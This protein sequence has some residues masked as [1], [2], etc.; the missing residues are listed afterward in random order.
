MNNNIV[1]ISLKSFVFWLIILISLATYISAIGIYFII[2]EKNL[3]DFTTK[4]QL[5]Y[6]NLIEKIETGEV[7]K[8][9][10][11][12]HIK[13]TESLLEA[14]Y[15]PPT[16]LESIDE[17]FKKT[18]LLIERRYNKSCLSCHQNKKIGESAGGFLIKF[19]LQESYL[20]S[21]KIN[22]NIFFLLSPIPLLG[23]YL[24][25]SFTTKKIDRFKNQLKKEIEHINKVEQLA[26]IE[27]I[28]KEIFILELDEIF[29]EL[30]K[31][32]KKTR[33]TAVDRD[34]LE[35]EIKILEKFLITSDV[36]KDWRKYV[37]SLIS[38]INQV[39]NIQ[40][41]FSLFRISENDFS[42]EFFWTSHPSEELKE[43]AEKMIEIRCREFYKPYCEFKSISVHHA[44][45]PSDKCEIFHPNMLH[46]E[47]KSLILEEPKIGG[48]IG[49]GVNT[50]HS[51]DKIK[52][53]VIEG[54][55]TTLL[56][57][58]GSV[59]AISRYNKEL[60]YYSTRDH[61]TNLFNQRVFWE[62]LTYQVARD[63]RHGRKFALLII[64]LDN[65]KFLN[66]NCGH[67][68][69]DRFLS[70]VS[71][72]IKKSVRLGDI[73]ARYSGDEFTVIMPETDSEEAYNVAIRLI[74]KI[75]KFKFH[76][77]DKTISVTAS[78]GYAI[79]PDHGSEA[80]ELFAFADTMLFKA[81]SEGKNK[82]LVP[83]D[84][85]I[86]F[87]N[88]MISEKSYQII[89][90]I[91]ENRIIPY[92]QPIMDLKT[93]SI[94]NYEVLCRIDMGDK[95][96]SAY[97]F[98][99]IAERTGNITKIDYLMMENAFKILT[100]HPGKTLFINLSPKSLIITEFIPNVLKITSK[101]G[102]KPDNI[103][104]ELT[105]R[106]TVKNISALEKFVANL[107]SEGYKFAI[108]DFGSGFSSYEYIK[109]FP[110]DFVK[111][112]GDFIK[113]ILTSSKD[114]A[115]VKSLLILTEEF[116]IK[117]IAEFIENQEI[118]DKIKELNINY[119]QGYFIG[120]PQKNMII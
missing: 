12:N 100:Q 88:R 113:N 68:V 96:V 16:K 17:S 5:R 95:I 74:D 60:E 45:I 91:E 93:G 67:D 37:A 20:A 85:D 73:V 8:F 58:I 9:Q 26:K 14:T 66:D 76:Q 80:K 65:F 52:S 47:T 86:A 69:G 1:K 75:E 97:E 118:F 31:F 49:V 114:M 28:K 23:A 81:K 35:F 77:K 90:A 38:D 120:K 109:R 64:D 71:D 111:I 25:A 98:I 104:F 72:I 34:I 99:E 3:R 117:T 19:S 53:L 55:L 89:R 112:D 105:E 18:H 119:G 57:V 63:K 40:L 30:N 102:V 59:K 106:E 4:E 41:V 101:Y 84:D 56:N 10:M 115:I 21:R 6:K 46:F 36:I 103:V 33:E 13:H 42:L 54:I 51:D 32:L 82:V 15:I 27:E 116:N 108:D 87:A 44:V 61:I 70:E 83:T 39:I 50:K 11:F 92:F 43:Y 7:Q 62:L 24:I 107:R 78:I 110:V 22:F 79:F 29:T 94:D 48:I 2:E